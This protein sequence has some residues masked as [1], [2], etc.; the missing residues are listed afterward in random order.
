MDLST[1][2]WTPLSS[3][4]LIMQ[5]KSYIIS[6]ISMYLSWSRKSMWRRRLNGPSLTLGIMLGAF[7]LL[8]ESWAFSIS[9]MKNVVLAI[10][11]MMHHLS[12]SCTSSL[13]LTP[14]LR[15]RTS[16]LQLLAGRMESQWTPW[17]LSIT[18]KNLDSPTCNSQWSIML[19][20]LSIP[21]IIFWRRI[22]TRCLKRFLNCYQRLL[23][24]F[25]NQFWILT[26]RPNSSKPKRL[27]RKL[28]LLSVA[29]C[30]SLHL[31]VCSNSPCISC[32]ILSV[33]LKFI[34]FVALSRMRINNLFRWTLHTCLNSWELV[35]F[36]RLSELV[37]LVIHLDFYLETL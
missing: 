29:V 16:P 8:K 27:L 26:I 14:S 7:S 37:V 36:L 34:T 33:L 10:A 11:E 32:Q 19:C 31:V 25:W 22:K 15:R 2:S 20:L 1:L 17:S 13:K 30:K 3:F 12:K 6:S 5:M 28:G 23:I 21:W 35:V 18:F 9:W 24:S 4:V